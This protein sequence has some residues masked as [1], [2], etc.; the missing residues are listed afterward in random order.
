MILVFA[1]LFGYALIDMQ[2]SSVTGNRDA[3][4][5]LT[6]LLLVLLIGIHIVYFLFDIVIKGKVICFYTMAVCLF[7]TIWITIVDLMRGAEAWAMLTHCGL[8]VLWFLSYYYF[9]A[10]F[11]AK[12][13]SKLLFNLLFLLFALYSVATVYYVRLLFGIRRYGVSNLSYNVL[14][15]FPWFFINTSERKRLSLIIVSAVV[16]AISM[17]RG[18]IIAFL[19]MMLFYLYTKGKIEEKAAK[20]LFLFIISCLVFA[21]VFF[22][23][24]RFLRGRLVL[25]FSLEQLQ[26]GSGRRE[27]YQYI[28]SLIRQR[29]LVDLLIGLGSGASVQAWGTG[30]HNEWLEFTFS[31][32]LVGALLYLWLVITL[33]KATVRY[34][35]NASKAYIP[36]AMSLIYMLTVG[37]VGG[38]YFMQSSYFIFALQGYLNAYFKEE[39]NLRRKI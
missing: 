22:V 16:I 24:N 21:G 11:N 38:I 9:F 37:M 33:I 35:R 25:R 7:I 10:S 30:A 32:G 29:N 20:Y 1:V 2:T 6:H 19:I 23:A 28:I 12:A 3:D 8:S 34:K 4:R 18:A 39:C 31:F 15:I 13:S 26:E 5:S 17:K 14:V 27:M 36:A